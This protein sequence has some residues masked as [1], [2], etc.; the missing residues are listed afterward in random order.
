M[1]CVLLEKS[2]RRFPRGRRVVRK[3]SNKELVKELSV[4]HFI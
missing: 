2:N 4:M 1:F 3:D